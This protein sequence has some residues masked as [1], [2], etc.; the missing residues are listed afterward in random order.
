MSDQKNTILAIVLSAIVLIG[1]Q[2]YF[3]L[4]QMEKQKQQQAQER[5]QHPPP[6]P[7]QPGTTQT[8]TAP[9]TAPHAPTQPGTVAQPMSRDAALAASPRVHIE[10]PSLSG[11]ISLKGGRIDDLSLV[12]YRETVDPNSPPI[13]LLAPSGSPHPFYAEFGWFPQSGVSLKLPNADTMWQQ[14]GAGTL[15]IGRPVTLVYDNGEGL[16]FRRTIAVDENYLFT[17]KDEVINKTAAPVTLYPFAPISRHG[18]PQTLGLYIVHEGLIGVFGDK[19]LQEETYADIEKQKAISFTAT[20]VWLGITDQ[21]WAATLLPDTKTQVQAKFS[22]GTIGNNIKTYQ[23]DY[24][25]P[26]QTIAP[27]STDVVDG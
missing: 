25:G 7:Q 24:L 1:W 16:Q 2:L 20:N 23:S 22:T 17:L 4:P 18:T 27:G 21:Y 9:G 5:S 3:G 12:K 13:V 10:T 8:P 19:G 11:S 26:A 15:G 14:E 6:V